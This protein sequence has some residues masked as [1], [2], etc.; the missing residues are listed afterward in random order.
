[1]L[2]KIKE[3]RSLWYLVR[4]NSWILYGAFIALAC[5]NWDIVVARHNLSTPDR[6]N[7]D[8]GYVLR[9]TDKALPEVASQPD[10]AALLAREP[11]REFTRKTGYYDHKEYFDRRIE[12]AFDRQ[13][14]KTWLS[15][16]LPRYHF[17]EYFKHAEK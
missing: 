13:E 5:V 4:T 17:L 8:I 2:F 3:T 6:A 14:D 9:L 12:R 10:F 16:N 15:W 11:N 7:I 1:M